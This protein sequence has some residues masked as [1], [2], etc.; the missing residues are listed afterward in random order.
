MTAMGTPFGFGE[1]APHAPRLRSPEG[2][3]RVHLIPRTL[4]ARAARKEF[5]LSTRDRGIHGKTSARLMVGP[6]II[7]PI[8]LMVLGGGLAVEGKKG[9]AKAVGIVFL[10]MGAGGLMVT[11]GQPWIGATLML[12]AFLYGLVRS[13]IA[14]R[15]R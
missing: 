8:L 4:E 15:R 9:F 6:E 12:A 11:L 3:E 5:P 10:L 1:R 14:Y 7:F 13:F 2:I